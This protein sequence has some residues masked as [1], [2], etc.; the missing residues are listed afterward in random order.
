MKI[1]NVTE[2]A[3]IFDNG[4]KIT[5]DHERDCCEYNYADFSILNPNV[6]N[7]DYDF[8]KPGAENNFILAIL[9]KVFNAIGFRYKYLLKNFIRNKLDNAPLYLIQ[10]SPIYKS[11]Q[12]YLKINDINVWRD[13]DRIST[14]FYS[15]SNHFLYIS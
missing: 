9:S 8:S 12:K 15:S 1:A 2:E 13:P 3:I 11:Y 5:F 6:V 4:N 7:Y 14:K 10:D